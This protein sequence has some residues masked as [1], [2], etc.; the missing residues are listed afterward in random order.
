MENTTEKK[1]TGKRRSEWNRPN[2]KA[3]ARLEIRRSEW[4]KNGDKTST[5]RPGSMKTVR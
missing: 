2:K 4:D 1:S 5:K 3:L